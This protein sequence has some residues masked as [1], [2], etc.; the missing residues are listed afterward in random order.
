MLKEFKRGMELYGSADIVTK[1]PKAARGL[2]VLGQQEAVDA[3]YLF[4]LMT[5]GHSPEGSS[6]RPLEEAIM[7]HF[8]DFLFNLEDTKVCGYQEA[9]A[10]KTDGL[11][12]R[13]KA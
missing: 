11:A 10:W 3:D 13:P 7:D 8:Q 12:N 2:F 9:L 4:S 1:H 6:R 5:P